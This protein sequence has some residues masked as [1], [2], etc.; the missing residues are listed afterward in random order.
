MKNIKILERAR[1]FEPLTCSFVMNCSKSVEL[2]PRKVGGRH[3]TRT[4]MRFRAAVFETAARPI[5]LAFRKEK[6]WGVRLWQSHF[7][8]LVE[9]I[10]RRAS[11]WTKNFGFGDRH[12]A[13]WVSLTCNFG[14]LEELSIQN[15][16]S[17]IQSWN[18][19][20]GKIWTFGA[21]TARQF[22]RLLA[23]NRRR[24]MREK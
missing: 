7:A 1:G 19:A 10:G 5:W 13:V 24:P 18:G 20:S 8:A 9:K 12:S 11:I 22:Y 17:K 6:V 3:R 16:K 4:R 14:E 21:Q 23:L 15:P 2:R